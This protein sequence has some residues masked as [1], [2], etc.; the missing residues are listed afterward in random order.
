MAS[1]PVHRSARF[2]YR[3]RFVLYIAALIVGVQCL[4][5][6]SFLSLDSQQERERIGREKRGGG[7]S[8][9]SQV[10]LTISIIHHRCKKR[11]YSQEE[12]NFVTICGSLYTSTGWKI[13]NWTSR[14]EHERRAC[15]YDCVKLNL[16]VHVNATQM[17]SKRKAI[18]WMIVRMQLCLMQRTLCCY[19]D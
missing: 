13:I 2:C 19:F 3:Y 4:V 7:R 16:R 1:G 15:R 9:V 6:W 8:P 18:M 11:K 10:S 14:D 5:M 12:T 17:T